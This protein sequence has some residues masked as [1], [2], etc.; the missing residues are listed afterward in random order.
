MSESN[1]VNAPAQHA[2]Q[3]PAAR[4]VA[5]WLLECCA[6][7]FAMVVAV[8]TRLVIFTMEPSA[9]HYTRGGGAK[10]SIAD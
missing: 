8:Y 1:V 5:A 10:V 7:V 9:H 6:L 4:Q 3:P 2:L